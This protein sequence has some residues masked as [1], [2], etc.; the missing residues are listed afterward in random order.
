MFHSSLENRIRFLVDIADHPGTLKLWSISQLQHCVYDV[1][2][3]EKNFLLNKSSGILIT[4]FNRSCSNSHPSIS[5]CKNTN[6]DRSFEKSSTRTVRTIE[7]CL[8]VSTLSTKSKRENSIRITRMGRTRRHGL[9]V[10]LITNNPVMADIEELLNDRNGAVVD[11]FG[12]LDDPQPMI[13]LR[14]RTIFI[15]E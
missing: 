9:M 7:Q 5:W 2:D 6:N 3:I 11:V 1:D 10:N 4:P 13:I 15:I 12:V 8:L 14:R